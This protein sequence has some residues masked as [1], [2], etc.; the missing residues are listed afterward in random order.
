M[1]APRHLTAI[2]AVSL[3]A[4]PAQGAEEFSAIQPILEAN[5]Y[6]CHG[7]EKTKGDIN[8]TDYTTLATIQ[9]NPKFW[10]NVA[11]TVEA[12]E[13]PPE[14]EKQPSDE[15]R[16]RLLAWIKD[17]V[18]NID[19]SKI[20]KDPGRPALRRLNREEYNNTI[21]DLFGVDFRPGKNFPEDG[22][23][24]GGF[25]NNG[26]ALFL[27]P[28]LMEK[29]LEAANA[30]L[31]DAFANERSRARL[32]FAA[33]AGDDPAEARAAA[34]KTLKFF[35]AYA[36]RRPVEDADL[37]P[38][39][40]L[41]DRGSKRGDSF[42]DSL[43]LALRG[44]LI[45]PRFLYRIEADKSGKAWKIDD[46]ELA[47]RLSYFLW[48]SMPDRDLFAAA[49]E[50]KLPSPPS[51]RRRSSACWR[52][53]RHRRWRTLRLGQWFGFDKLKTTANPDPERYPQ[54]TMPLRVAMYREA[55]EFFTSLLR[56][57]K[58]ILYLLHSDYTYANDVLAR[59]YG[60]PGVQGSEMRPVKLPDRNRGG[61]L[62]MGAIQVATSLPLRTSPAIRGKWVLEEL[63][64]TPPPP[65]PQNAGQLPQDDRQPDGLTFRQRLEL[66][67]REPSCAGCHKRMDPL[68]FGLENFD[69]IGRWRTEQNG[70]PIDAAGELPTGE[71]FASPADLKR[72]LLTRREAFARHMTEKM[73]SYA[74]GRGVGYTDLPTIKSVGEAVIADDYKIG[75]MVLE[76]A[77]SY[78]FQH[79]R[80]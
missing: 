12:G 31:A 74:L 64:G 10:E 21:R 48:S 57:D 28:I 44:V 37:A 53:K 15:E 72:I 20:P 47:S 55:T 38:Y 13:M 39:L 76:I 56:E 6:R 67:R 32:L 24:D 52:T 73:L 60:I 51:W 41:F 62:G 8:L 30:V 54:F 29:Y 5:C 80:N 36:F 26:D 22:A 25:N 50:G 46:F 69:A 75:T 14:D 4:P 11:H 18:T 71:S 16:K 27:P 7:G 45:S 70:K 3:L 79:R 77:K 2:A 58:S 35:G 17:A 34:E 66:H 63:L 9:R 33:P 43:K 61:V 68:G 65:P 40:A 23:G 78:P 42:A 19:Y 1:P 49:A 59:H